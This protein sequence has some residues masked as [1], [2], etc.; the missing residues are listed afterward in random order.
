MVFESRIFAQAPAGSSELTG[1]LVDSTFRFAVCTRAQ[2]LLM[3]SGQSA[4][5]LLPKLLC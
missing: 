1:L 3:G 5:L 4:T 2:K